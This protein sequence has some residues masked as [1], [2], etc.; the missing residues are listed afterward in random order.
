MPN[1]LH[2]KSVNPDASGSLVN[3]VS[4]LSRANATDDR[5]SHLGISTRVNY[6]LLVDCTSLRAD[7]RCGSLPTHVCLIIG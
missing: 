1:L 2:T 6:P 7:C 4:E 5:P 3:L